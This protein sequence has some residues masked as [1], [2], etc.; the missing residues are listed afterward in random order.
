VVF[1]EAGRYSPLTNATALRAANAYLLYRAPDIVIAPLDTL[2]SAN[3]GVVPPEIL[4][5][6]YVERLVDPHAEAAVYVRTPAPLI[7]FRSTPRV[8]L[9]NLVHPSRLVRAFDGTSVPR[10]AYLARLPF[11]A[12]GRLDR[13]FSGRATYDLVFAAVDEPV[14]ELDVRGVWARTDVVM[15]LTLRNANGA[16]VHREE[17]L[18]IGGVPSAVA[19]SWPGGQPAAELSLVLESR[20][21]GPTRVLLHDLRVQGQSPELAGYVR[22]LPFPPPDGSGR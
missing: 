13:S 21:G 6:H 12:D 10:D 16:L 19:L 7:E 20:T 15:T 8:F 2:R 17:R 22:Q 4:R 3:L 11:L 9:E 1:T 18:L 14:F 5:G